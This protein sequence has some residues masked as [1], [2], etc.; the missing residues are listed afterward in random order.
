[1]SIAQLTQSI[2]LQIQGQREVA[3]AIRGV[4]Q[5]MERLA[6]SFDRGNRSQ[7]RHNQTSEETA[8]GL[9][10]IQS[11]LVQ[12]STWLL[13]TNV[14]INNMFDNMTRRFT[15]SET[16]MAQLKVTMGLAGQ[17]AADP[18][19]SARFS[20]FDMFKERIDE[21]ALTTEYTKKQVADAFTSLVQ[22]GRTGTEA[23]KMLNS[24]LQLATASGGQLNLAGAIDVATL[25]IGTLGGGVEEVDQNLNMLLR[26]S[27]K[28][29]IGFKD[30]QQ[31]LSSLRASYSKF[32]ETSGV[33]REAEIMALAAA[34]RT[35]G[36]SAANSGE[37]VDQFSRSL[38]GLM[39]T[40]SKGELRQLKGMK[41]AGRFSMKRESL[42]QFFGVGQMSKEQINDALETN[43]KDVELARDEFVKRQIM[44]F[45]KQTGKYEQKSVSQ[46]I[47]TLVGAYDTLVKK[48]GDKAKSTAKA[49]FG[50]ESAQFMLDAIVQMSKR[51]GKGVGESAK[52]F[53]DLIADI[54]KNMSDLSKAQQEVLK[55]LAKRI[56][57]VESA[58]DSLSNTIFQH[59][60]YANAV[61]DTYRETISAT[62]TL[63]KNNKSLAVATSFLGRVL[64]VLTG[65][66][67]SFGFML[68]ATATFSMALKGA[69][70][71]TSVAAAGL[72]TTLRAFSRE[73][74]LPT[75]SVLYRLT[76][77]IAVLSI[78]IVALMRYFSGAEGI[79][80]GFK[81]V[82]E[83][84]SDAARTTGALI[85]FAFSPKLAKKDL[86][87][88]INDYYKYKEQ[89][90][91]IDRELYLH[92][93]GLLALSKGEINARMKLQ[94]EL[95]NKMVDLNNVLGLPGRE[96]LDKMG[97]LKGG[98]ETVNLLGEV[99]Q[100][101]KNL[102]NG[103]M[104][105][106]ESA[107]IPIMATLGLVFNT[108][109]ITVGVLLVP[110]RILANL[111]GFASDEGSALRYVLEFVGTAL[112]VVI[113]YLMV[114]KSISLFV[115]GLTGVANG[116]RSL[117]GGVQNYISSAATMQQRLNSNQQAWNMQ[118][119]AVDRVRLEY[120]K[121]TNQTQAYNSEITRLR[122]Q[123]GTVTT[124]MNN[125]GTN[126]SNVFASTTGRIGGATAA[127][128]GFVSVVGMAFG[129][130][131]AQEYG[132]NILIFGSLLMGLQPIINGVTALWAR[133]TLA[134]TL[135]GVSFWATWG[136]ILLALGVV[137]GGIYALTKLMGKS[138][139]KKEA[140]PKKPTTANLNTLATPMA[141]GMVMPSANNGSS[142][143]YTQGGQMVSPTAMASNN[144]V[145]TIASPSQN[146]NNDY[147]K[148]IN[149]RQVNMK[150]MDNTE[151]SLNAL[152]KFGDDNVS[153]VYTG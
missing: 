23:M 75:I 5:S 127:L 64:Q 125:M 29:K 47:K 108:L 153:G 121:L 129:S 72:G 58:E 71:K 8:Q 93:K 83:K 49:A 65:F 34:A 84:I 61:L 73:Y 114:T 80:E 6:G 67:T 94:D 69:M 85:Q 22:S 62:D 53:S 19:F 45:D 106:G 105:I 136:P 2:N 146:V 126:I 42:L 133:F 141:S 40:V 59:D 107:I 96:I 35:M 79:G 30:L 10:N 17:S 39:S 32:N 123:T 118:I 11:G 122:T 128:G 98:R 116:F 144:T 66:G 135:S 109:K 68:V 24:T 54:S 56:A 139:T 36:L 44:T 140:V 55:T 97:V 50:T 113:S 102:A 76:G 43:F 12:L 124:A 112:G 21:L 60:V 137:F 14:K 38:L 149:I 57:L 37:K 81:I 46:L 77:G 16:A 92:S 41:S 13:N 143:V 142:S 145:A 86:S 20:E 91:S 132:N 120:L 95:T 48:E 150:T 15:E 27:Q 117:V 18:M 78:G 51:A 25:T 147:S 28:T 111:F 104:I 100:S 130:E 119:P 101:I 26:T 63:M 89:K 103:F 151:K 138:S 152:M 7:K 4:T 131:K 110:I 31:V 33:S 1:M 134:S 3:N 148:T 74:L 82:L 52:V 87:T 70:G 88:L 99:L 115:A 9:F 90:K